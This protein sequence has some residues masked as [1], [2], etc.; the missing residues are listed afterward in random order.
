MTVTEFLLLGCWFGGL[1]SLTSVLV[2]EP[3]HLRKARDTETLQKL[4][5]TRLGYG[6]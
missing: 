3:L 2:S 1:F 6:Q 4:T 5:E